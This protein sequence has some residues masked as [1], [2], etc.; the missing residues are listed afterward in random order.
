MF[1]EHSDR[2]NWTDSIQGI[3]RN[4]ALK[5]KLKYNV[6]WTLTYIDKQTDLLQGVGTNSTMKCIWKCNV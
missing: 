3:A 4:S 5:Y 1:T 2:P 6:Y